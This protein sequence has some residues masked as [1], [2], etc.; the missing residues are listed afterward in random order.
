M[1][2][3]AHVAILENFHHS[4]LTGPILASR[5]YHSICDLDNCRAMSV[6]ISHQSDTDDTRSPEPTA[7]YPSDVPTISPISEPTRA[8]HDILPPRAP[9]SPPLIVPIE[10]PAPSHPIWSPVE[11]RTSQF[12]IPIGYKL[13]P[14]PKKRR[15]V[16]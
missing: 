16:L 8:L 14:V 10:Q 1:P 3:T 4:L 5:K 2:P 15:R 13:F 7:C 12:D 6:P 11:D 9:P